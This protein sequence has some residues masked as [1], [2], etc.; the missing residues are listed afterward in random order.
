MQYVSLLS[1][2]PMKVNAFWGGGSHAKKAGNIKIILWLLPI[3]QAGE[4]S[5]IETKAY[6][7]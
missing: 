6:D 3:I 2:A 4:T 1:A 5:L 7:S